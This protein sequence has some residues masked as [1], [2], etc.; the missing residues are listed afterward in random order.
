MCRDSL[1]CAAKNYYIIFLG[2]GNFDPDTY[3]GIFI[4]RHS[5]CGVISS[6]QICEF[7]ECCLSVVVVVVVV[8]GDDV[9]ATCKIVT[10]QYHVGC[11]S[12]LTS[13]FCC[14]L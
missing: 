6:L 13:H 12:R 8:D 3:P 7:S 11:A 14:D 10:T 4:H 1:H 9:M 2:G 5:L